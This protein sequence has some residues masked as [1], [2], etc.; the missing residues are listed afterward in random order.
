[1]LSITKCKKTL[2]KNGDTYTEK[3]I[4]LVRDFLSLIA[5]LHYKQ[6]KSNEEKET[7]VQK[8]N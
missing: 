7:Y 3:E 2:N 1:M 6:L 5:E 8:R 4:E